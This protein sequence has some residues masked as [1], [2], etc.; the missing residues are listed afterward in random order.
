[1]FNSLESHFH[2]AISSETCLSTKED[3]NR[4]D[5]H[6]STFKQFLFEF[7]ST[8]S[9][10]LYSAKENI[11]LSQKNTSRTLRQIQ[12]VSSTITYSNYLNSPSKV[13]DINIIESVPFLYYPRSLYAYFSNCTNANS[14]QYQSDDFCC[15]GKISTITDFDQDSDFD[16]VL[17]N[18][19]TL[20]QNEFVR[21]SD[22]L[23]QNETQNSNNNNENQRNDIIVENT[24]DTENMG[25]LNGSNISNINFIKEQV[26]TSGVKCLE[27]TNFNFL[28]TSSN[29]NNIKHFDRNNTSCTSNKG[30]NL[31]YDGNLNIVNKHISNIESFG[32]VC[33]LCKMPISVTRRNIQNMHNIQSH[34]IS[35]PEGLNEDDNFNEV[36]FNG[37]N[38]LSPSLLNTQSGYSNNLNREEFQ[39]VSQD[40]VIYSTNENANNLSSRENLTVSNNIQ[41]V[42]KRYN[43][44]LNFNVCENE[45]HRN[46]QC[47]T[48][49]RPGSIYSNSNTFLEQKLDENRKR[50]NVHTFE[51]MGDEKENINPSEWKNKILTENELHHNDDISR[52]VL[53]TLDSNAK[54]DGSKYSKD[55]DSMHKNISNQRHNIPDRWCR[56][57]A[58]NTSIQSTLPCPMTTSPNHI[59]SSIKPQIHQEN[60]HFKNQYYNNHF[61]STLQQNNEKY[62]LSS[63]PASSHDHPPDTNIQT[64]NVLPTGNT[65]FEGKEKFSFG[66]FQQSG[67][68]YDGSYDN[69]DLEIVKSSIMYD[70]SSSSTPA[71]AVPKR[72]KGYFDREQKDSASMSWS[73][74]HTVNQKFRN[75]ETSVNN[76]SLQVENDDFSRYGETGNNQNDGR[77]HNFRHSSTHLG[78]HG[79]TGKQEQAKVTFVHTKHNTVRKLTNYKEIVTGE[80][81]ET[82]TPGKYVFFIFPERGFA[83]S[84]PQPVGVRKLEGNKEEIIYSPYHLVQK[85]LDEIGLKTVTQIRL[86][87]HYATRKRGICIKG[88]YNNVKA[89]AEVVSNQLT[90]WT[91]TR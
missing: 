15:T 55:H 83:K 4:K 18:F 1:M 38:S 25:I 53:N 9:W 3:K 11:S 8:H 84:Q 81:L 6:L 54:Y 19:D 72:K 47:P 14:L 61:R 57:E 76:Q 66:N 51:E 16:I 80:I 52:I 45:P 10:L 78:Q 5:D 65:I 79:Y 13:S 73:N 56:N 22:C 63:Q 59:G 75:R 60:C 27:I 42:N 68:S 82:G 30:S 26:E 39:T 24:D 41:E 89:A 32:N 58:K 88:G 12:T 37:D 23:G 67:S 70:N 40:N 29:N 48:K 44:V 69:H 33:Q 77:I 87:S 85:E 90:N 91:W 71:V 2:L 43:Y 49:L 34:K 36:Y 7:L 20:Y 50:P 74:K 64:A 62:P 46:V 17:S 28:N 31:R 35:K 21:S 86:F